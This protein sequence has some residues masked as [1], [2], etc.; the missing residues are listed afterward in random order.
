M[1]MMPGCECQVEE[2]YRLKVLYREGGQEQETRVQAGQR[3]CCEK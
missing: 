2:G 1:E 3:R